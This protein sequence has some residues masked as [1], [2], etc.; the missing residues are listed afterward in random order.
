[1]PKT[2]K[3]E[4]D[5]SHEIKKRERE[6]KKILEKFVKD[7]NAK[8][9]A[10]PLKLIENA[11][12]KLSKKYFQLLDVTIRQYLEPGT[13]ANKFKVAS[14]SEIATMFV[15][16][17]A[18][19]DPSFTHMERRRI[20]AMLAVQL[21]ITI[22]FSVHTID[23]EWPNLYENDALKKVISTHVLWLSYLEVSNIESVPTFINSNFWE[24]FF[25]ISTGGYSK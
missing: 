24:L 17:L 16:P 1:M 15:L 10:T 4:G 8:E 25:V 21:A 18:F 19:K 6:I 20:N 12:K 2:T 7:W 14:G 13:Y 9:T 5:S 3:L 11:A 23:K 22:M